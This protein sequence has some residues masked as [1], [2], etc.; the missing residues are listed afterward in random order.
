MYY[1]GSKENIAKRF[2]QKFNY[3]MLLGVTKYEGYGQ[4]YNID[5]KNNDLVPRTLLPQ[6]MNRVKEIDYNLNLA[7]YLLMF[8]SFIYFCHQT[9]VIKQLA[10]LYGCR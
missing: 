7:M 1:R 10:F 5:K 8:E 4:L 6:G 9:I 2:C 3:S